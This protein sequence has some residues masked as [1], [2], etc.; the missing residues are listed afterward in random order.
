MQQE[1]EMD[2]TMISQLQWIKLEWFVD[3]Q[4]TAQLQY[5]FLHLTHNFLLRGT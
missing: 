3:E 1:L 5:C 2:E 4:V